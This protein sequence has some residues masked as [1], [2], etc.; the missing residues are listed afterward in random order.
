[1]I[2][3]LITFF[4]I[5]TLICAKN[6]RYG[7]YVVIFSMPLYL[8]RFSIGGIPSTALEMMIYILFLV[9]ILT[10]VHS[11]ECNKSWLK[12][13][14]SIYRLKPELH[15]LNSLLSKN[16]IL[17]A[18]ILLLFLGLTISTL[19][20][21]DL[22]TSLGIFKGWFF[23]SF[24][25]F[26]VFVSVVKKNKHIILSLKSWALSSV[27]VSLISIFYLLNNELTFDGRLKAFF[28]SPN[29]LAMYLAPAFLIALFFLLN[30]RVFSIFLLIIFVP[31]YF[32]YSYG[33]FLGI[34]AGILYLAS[35]DAINR[36]STVN[37]FRNRV[38]GTRNSVS[39]YVF[40]L[41]IIF[42][43]FIFIS[44]NKFNQITNSD[45]RSSFHS[46]LMIWNSAGEIIKDNP[47]FGI[48][49]GTFQ[50]TYLSYAE[51]F[52]EQYLEWA[53][54]QPHN[55]F[56]AFYLQ[57]GLIGFI[58]FILILFWFFK[59]M[60]EAVPRSYNIINALMIYTLIHGLVDTTYWKN[61]LSL[62]FWLLIGMAIVGNL[63]LDKNQKVC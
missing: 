16:K 21:T 51:K 38:S 13:T 9:W 2:I 14:N 35:R 32:T 23:D 33:A 4:L 39:V 31:L 54:P 46:R 63:A 27:A 43:G 1:M 53:V 17:L 58:G 60:N 42:A 20:S 3:F 37:I 52:D 25:F 48:G 6:I 59:R 45:S 10:G 29:H 34:F 36:V 22:R 49:P 61:D 56:L 55:I 44:S 26:I 18:G 24:L 30:K 19:N 40:L 47:L 50:K 62:M 41:I 12:Q 5:F 7:V 28:L 11:L 8:V 15:D 57:T